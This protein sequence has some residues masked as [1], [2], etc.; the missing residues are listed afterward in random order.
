MYDNEHIIDEMGNISDY[1]SNV[2][3][4]D[5]NLSNEEDKVP[6]PNDSRALERNGRAK[7]KSYSM[8]LVRRQDGNVHGSRLMLSVSLALSG[9]KKV[10][11]L[12]R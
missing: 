11:K 5:E 7:E 8:A 6:T 10:T 9:T 3:F 2:S 12:R 4:V 1:N